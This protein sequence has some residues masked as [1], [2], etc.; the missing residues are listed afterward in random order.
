MKSRR[1]GQ[2]LEPTTICFR[3][4][5]NDYSTNMVIELLDQAGFKGTYDFVYVPHDFRRLPSLVN[6]GYFF[7]NFVS[8]DVAKSALDKLAGFKNWAVLSSK[9]LTGAWATK[10]QGKDACIERCRHFTLM[11]KHIPNECR[12]MVFE[13]GVAHKL[14]HSA[15]ST[16]DRTAVRARTL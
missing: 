10:T 16:T 5:P 8:H 2:P 9:V 12:P 3:N 1:G 15:P 13:L 7:A 4:I 14:E 6:I 11:Y